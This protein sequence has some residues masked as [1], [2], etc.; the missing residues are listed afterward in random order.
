MKIILNNTGDVLDFKGFKDEMKTLET[1]DSCQNTNCT[2][3]CVN[4]PDDKYTCMCPDGF[5]LVGDKCLCPDKKTEPYDNGTCPISACK[6]DTDDS[7]T[8][9]KDDVC[10]PKRWVFKG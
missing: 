1:R 3:M 6:N 7:F 9:K 2:M 8:C 4:L 10:I 5:Y